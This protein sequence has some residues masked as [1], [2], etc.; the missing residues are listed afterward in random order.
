M[1]RVGAHAAPLRSV[2]VMLPYVPMHHVRSGSSCLQLVYQRA[3]NYAIHSVLGP[4]ALSNE[5]L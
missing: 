5:M 4:T 2:E 3:I 1:K